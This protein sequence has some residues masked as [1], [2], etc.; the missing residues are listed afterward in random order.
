[1]TESTA[2]ATRGHNSVGV[3]KHA[4]VGLLSPNSQAKV[5]DWVNG[6]SLPPGSIGELWLRSPGIMRGNLFS[7]DSRLY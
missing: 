1:M 4:S 3:R 7:Q 5:V 2:V 6:A